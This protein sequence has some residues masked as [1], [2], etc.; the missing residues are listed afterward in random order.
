M[1]KRET[2]FAEQETTLARLE[3]RMEELVKTQRAQMPSPNHWVLGVLGCQVRKR[4]SK[5][6]TN[7]TITTFAE[8]SIVYGSLFTEND[9]T[10]PKLE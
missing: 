3:K 2:R 9:E 8:V 6:L 1:S 7:N 4:V 5:F 10:T